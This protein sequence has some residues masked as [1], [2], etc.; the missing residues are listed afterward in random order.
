MKVDLFDVL[1]RIVES[2]N[3]NLRKISGSEKA[4]DLE[5]VGDLDLGLRRMLYGET[6][7]QEFF[8]G[9][10]EKTEEGI[11]YCY[12]DS[13]GIEYIILRLPQE[14]QGE[15]LFIGPYMEEMI[16]GRQFLDMME[17]NHVPGNYMKGVREYYNSIPC[18]HYAEQWRTTCIRLFQL[19]DPD[20]QLRVEQIKSGVQETEFHQETDEDGLY[21]RIVEERYAIEV[22]MLLAVENGDADTALSYMRDS[23]KYRLRKRYKDSIRDIRNS[24]I[25]LNTLCRKA[26][27]MGGVH[28]VHIDEFSEHLAIQCEKV[29]TEEEAWKMR[30][31]LLRRY[32]FLIQNYSMRGYS[33]IVRNVANHINLNFSKKLSLAEL[34]RMY[35]VNPSYLSSLFKKEMGVTVSEYIGKQRMHQAIRLFNTGYVQ[36]AE[37]A[38]LCGIDDTSYFRKVFRKVVGMTPSEYIKMLHKS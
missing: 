10:L 6:A 26:A 23:Y 5:R 12:T 34:A 25:S 2:N 24:L 8:S 1:G 3:V 28:P 15:I 20:V 21:E 32:C 4:E 11:C 33:A 7:S 31:E 22:K 9:V 13:Y 14:E 36:V 27:E 35:A 17:Y 37:V 38:M 16:E 19:Y 18:V 30:A 29:M